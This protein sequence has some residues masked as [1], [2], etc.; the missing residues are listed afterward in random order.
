MRKDIIIRIIQVTI[1]LI[2]IYAT[3]KVDTLL[4]LLCTCLVTIYLLE[5][6]RKEE[7]K[8]RN[9]TSHKLVDNDIVKRN[10]SST[11]LL[12]DLVNLFDRNLDFNLYDNKAENTIHLGICK[13]KLLKH[14]LYLDWKVTTIEVESN[15]DLWIYIE[16]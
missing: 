8:E 3:Y 1:Q 7:K 15:Y 4:M 9:L 14:N 6:Y 16:K 2:L 12:K 11:I 5:N 10:T 13:E